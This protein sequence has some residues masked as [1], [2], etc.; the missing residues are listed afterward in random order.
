MDNLIQFV[1]IIFGVVTPLM[2][3]IFRFLFKKSLAFRI[4]VIVVALLDTISVLSFINGT[5]GEVKAMMYMG[6]L[7][8]SIIIIGFVMIAKTFKKIIRLSE[9]IEVIAGG[10]ISVEVDPDL[11]DRSDEIGRIARA[12]SKMQGNQNNI[13]RNIKSSSNQ[14]IDASNNLSSV[15][16]QLSESSHEQAATTEQVASAME[17]MLSAI[18]SNTDAANRTSQI[19]TKSADG[20]EDSNSA[21]ME[22]IKSV[23]DISQKIG[24]ISDIAFQTNILSLNA[25]VE[26]ARAGEAGKGFAVVAQEIRKLADTAN[27]ASS[28][29]EALSKSG[30]TL[31]E[32]AREKLVKI[33]PEIKESA[34]MV[35]SI[36][37]SSHEQQSGAEIINTSIQQLTSITN[38]NSTSSEE[39]S[40]SAEELSAQAE[41]LKELISL[42]NTEESK[43]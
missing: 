23:N 42:F 26:A 30:I 13:I 27:K 33:V 35:N 32:G 14:L 3:I 10:N 29:I 17:E 41:Q 7:G 12:L 16:R 40:T 34:E 31:S 15:A 19:S 5:G 28:E 38:Q 21:F 36:A 18:R 43:N 4:G 37:S 39:M 11:I 2:I 25:S 24:I 22:T 6:P 9:T 1:A 20:I 8:V